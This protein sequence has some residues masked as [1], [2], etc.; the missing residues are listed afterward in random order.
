M[1]DTQIWEPNPDKPGY[2]KYQGQVDIRTINQGIC[3]ALNAIIL[4]DSEPEWISTALNEAHW[5]NGPIDRWTDETTIDEWPEKTEPI[6]SVVKG[7]NEGYHL[8]ILALDRKGNAT[9][10][11]TIKYLTGWSDVWR[12]AEELDKH[13]EVH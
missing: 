9:L 3:D 12:I 13:F 2:L 5:I 7:S 8:L 1:I 6:V 11:Y 10:I 4:D